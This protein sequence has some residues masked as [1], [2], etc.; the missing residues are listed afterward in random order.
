[1]RKHTEPLHTI[2]IHCSATPEGRAD[3]IHD[4][5]RWHVKERHW[6]AIGYH[7][8]IELDG[9]PLVGR[10]IEYQGAHVRG[11]N[12]GTIGVCYVGGMSKDMK[13]PKDT[14]T[15]S[16]KEE[17]K[18]LIKALKFFYGDHLKVVGHTELDSGKACPSFDVQKEY[19]S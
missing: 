10:P 5:E 4:I 8:V 6:D 12:D 15:D 2:V 3:T 7:F 19:I 16:Q 14:R 13:K 11:H 1:V 18:F 9:P 17:L